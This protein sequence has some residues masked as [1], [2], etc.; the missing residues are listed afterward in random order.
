MARH[1]DHCKRL[2]IQ[3]MKGSVPVYL[4]D[5]SATVGSSVCLKGKLVESRGTQDV[6]LQVAELDVLGKSP[7]SPE[8]PRVVGA[9]YAAN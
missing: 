3:L 5:I 7:E 8:E 2:L 1:I 9:G 4:S 6:E